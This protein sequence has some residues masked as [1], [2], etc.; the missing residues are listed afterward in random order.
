MI[1]FLDGILSAVHDD[2]SIINVNG[3]GYQIYVSQMTRSQLPKVDETLKLFIYHHIREDQQT[4]YGFPTL[5]ERDFFMLLTTVSGIG[6]KVGIKMLSVLTPI[7]ISEA[8]ARDDIMTLT[9]VPGIGKKVAERMLVELKDKVP[10]FFDMDLTTTDSVSPTEDHSK[11]NE[12]DLVLALKTLGYRAD[13]IKK[14]MIQSRQSLN[15]DTSIEEGM[16]ILLN[17]L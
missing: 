5:S 7:K 13:E 9:T 17:H 3:V 10:Q 11:N 15:P 4:L 12:E 6:P 16:K 2:F 1:Y 8:I 14:A